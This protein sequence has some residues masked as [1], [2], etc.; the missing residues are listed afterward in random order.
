MNL[1]CECGHVI[2]TPMFVIK[3]EDDD[4]PDWYLCSVKCLNDFVVVA[5]AEVLLDSVEI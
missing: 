3:Y 4:W 2:G 1:C 5:E